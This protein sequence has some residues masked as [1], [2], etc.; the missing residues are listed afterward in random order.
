MNQAPTNQ[1][2]TIGINAW[3]TRLSRN[4]LP[5]LSEVMREINRLTSGSDTSVNQLSEVILRDASLTA[6]VLRLSNSAYFNPHGEQDVTTISRA[7]V[8]LGFQGIKAISLSV[9]LIDS[10]L[11]KGAKQRMLEWLARGFHAAVQAERLLGTRGQPVKEDAFI[12]ALL[13]HVGDMAFWSCRGEQ[14]LAL[15]RAL[16][17]KRG[18]ADSERAVLGTTLR[19]ITQQLA[20]VWQL[21]QTL[22]EALQDGDCDTH[23]AQA[24]RL[25]E[26]ISLAAEDGWNSPAL[27]KVLDK[28]AAF[29][30]QSR[31]EA[32]EALLKGAEDAAAVALNYG[33]NKVCN[34]IPSTADAQLA[35]V[36]KSKSD[37]QLQLSILRELATMIHENVDANTLFQTVVEGVH[38]AIG[39]ERVALL[40]IDPKKKILQ[41]KY[42]LSEEGTEWRDAMQFSMRGEQDNLFSYCLYSRQLLWMRPDKPGQLKHLI[43]IDSRKT[44]DS[45]NLVLSSLYAGPRQIGVLFADRGPQGDPIEQEQYESFC[46]FAQQANM[47][48]SMLADRAKKKT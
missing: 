5:V 46:H 28:V 32:R 13:L 45:T 43:D 7:V 6:K 3:V 47:G 39:F 14:M 48:L 10:L 33:A 22:N 25:G 31:E 12:A 30:G 24:V 23:T 36:K 27:E 18:N 15:E 26:E 42:A 20:G 37:A 11:K 35:P 9:M 41:A 2:N 29:T 44:V 4:E 16:G 34:F 40:L 8:K 38:R 17:D 19:E 1:T 21:G